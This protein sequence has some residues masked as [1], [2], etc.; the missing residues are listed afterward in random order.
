[1][2]KNLFNGNIRPSVVDLAMLDGNRCKPIC[3]LTNILISVGDYN[4]L[5]DFVVSE[6]QLHRKASIILG[7]C[8]LAPIDAWIKVKNRIIVPRKE[9]RPGPIR[10]YSSHSDRPHCIWTNKRPDEF[11]QCYNRMTQNPGYRPNYTSWTL[12]KEQT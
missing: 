12:E 9:G 1:M 10:M 4:V 2:L 11:K 8:P 5:C 7:H 6:Q 3:I